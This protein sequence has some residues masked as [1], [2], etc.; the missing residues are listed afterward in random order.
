MKIKLLLNILAIT[1]MIMACERPEVGY[2]SDHIFYNVNPFDVQK[3]VTTYSSTIVANGSTAPLHVELLTVKN[4]DGEDITEAFTEP[5]NIVTFAGTITW[6]DS[7]LEMLEAKLTDSLVTPFH[8]N[9]I[10]GR[11]EFSAATAYLAAGSYQIDVQISN[12]K[13]AYA[14]ED[15]CA[16]NL[17]EVEDAYSMNYKRVQTNNDDDNG[18]SQTAD[19]YI[20]VD[21]EYISGGDKSM[22]IY[23]FLD[24]NGTLFNPANNEVKRRA[25]NYPFFDDWNPW[26]ELVVTDTAF[27]HQMP[28]FQGIDFPYFSELVVGG[29]TWSDA[30]ARYD[31]KIPKANIAELDRDLYGLISFQFHSTGTFIIT[32]QLHQ[33]TRKDG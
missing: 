26:Y 23:K 15:A 8:I 2:L 29:D 27:V 9:E 14:I 10:G 11:L 12:S 13:C 31:W 33:F 25:T 6:K 3:G 32:T 7:T 21:V 30:S 22:C 4:E 1:L 20:T 19:S 24:K 18:I 5:G 28:H 17:T 16:I